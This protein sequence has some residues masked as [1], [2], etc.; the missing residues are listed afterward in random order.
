MPPSS[1]FIIQ[2]SLPVCYCVLAKPFILSVPLRFVISIL[3]FVSEPLRFVI[4]IL[5]LESEPLRLVI[6]IL[7]FELEPLLFVIA[8][9]R[10][11]SEPLRFVIPILLFVNEPLFFGTD[12]Y[13]ELQGAFI[14]FRVAII[15]L[16][17]EI[18]E[19]I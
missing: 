1:S 5:R 15:E 12:N 19:P 17:G 18:N 9:L 10:F 3:R 14:E 16:L 8:I 11:V 7:L 6:T 4:A 2:L 13:I